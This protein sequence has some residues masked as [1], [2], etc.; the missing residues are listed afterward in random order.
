MGVGMIETKAY[1][2]TDSY[3]YKDMYFKLLNKF[4]KMARMTHNKQIEFIISIEQDKL[5]Q[6]IKK[7]DKQ[8]RLT[9]H[10]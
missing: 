8:N 3:K 5:N 2:Y 4:E 9:K 10:A 1:M 7:K 6:L